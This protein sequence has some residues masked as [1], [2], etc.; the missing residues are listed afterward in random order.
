VSLL[1]S[2]LSPPPRDS[3]FSSSL[4]RCSP[5]LCARLAC[6]QPCPADA[7]AW[8]AVGVARR[9]QPARPAARPARGMVPGSAACMA[10]P[11]WPLLGPWR[12]QRSTYTQQGLRR[13]LG[14]R[15]RSVP[16]CSPCGMR[17]SCSQSRRPVPACVMPTAFAL[18]CPCHRRSSRMAGQQ[19]P[20]LSLCTQ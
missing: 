13:G 10:W 18:H 11:A 12:G 15:V 16:Q 6:A 19:Y 8:P 3:L 7:P 5:W 4:T 14:R 20:R 9:G 1:P 2:S 17:G